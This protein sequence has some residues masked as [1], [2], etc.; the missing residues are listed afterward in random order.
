L[1]ARIVSHIPTVQDDGSVTWEYLLISEAG[2]LARVPMEQGNAW[3]GQKSESE[4]RF[5]QLA[6]LGNDVIVNG[7]PGVIVTVGPGPNLVQVMYQ[8]GKSESV[9]INDLKP[10][11]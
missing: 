4:S 9:K 11:S 5:E 10:A 3:Q 8:D 6:E 1:K 2:E 7:K